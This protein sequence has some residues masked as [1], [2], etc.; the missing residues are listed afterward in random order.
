[1]Q[2]KAIWLINKIQDLGNK[3]DSMQKFWGDGVSSHYKEEIERYK[4]LRQRS[5][6]DTGSYELLVRYDLKIA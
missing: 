2:T 5:Y 1:M 3:L 4:K 6:K